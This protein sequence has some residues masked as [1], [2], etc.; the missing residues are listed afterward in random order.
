MWGMGWVFAALIVVVIC[1]AFLAALGRLGQIAPQVDDRPVPA[2]PSDR[3]LVASDLQQVRFAV[4]TRG[5]SMAQVEALLDRVCDELADSGPRD[6]ALEAGAVSS[7]TPI[8]VAAAQ[9][10]AGVPSGYLGPVPNG[11]PR[12]MTRSAPPVEPDA[13]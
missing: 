12:T 7:A 1:F 4:V 2:L 13:E 8:Q 3:R 5:Y 11:W 10:Q 6:L 9:P